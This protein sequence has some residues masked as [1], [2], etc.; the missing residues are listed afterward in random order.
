MCT[1]SSRYQKLCNRKLAKTI[2]R[3]ELI[4]MSLVLRTTCSNLTKPSEQN[5]D[6][7]LGYFSNLVAWFLTTCCERRLSE[8]R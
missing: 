7:K 8:A 4:A 1:G 5:R 3:T 2:L 6:S